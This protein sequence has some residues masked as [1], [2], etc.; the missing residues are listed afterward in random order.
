LTLSQ[1]RALRDFKL[2]FLPRFFQKAGGVWG[3]APQKSQKIT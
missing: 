1:N 2:K 3:E